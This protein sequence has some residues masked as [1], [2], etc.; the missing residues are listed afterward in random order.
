LFVR[1]KSLIVQ[2]R[3]LVANLP[4]ARL[5]FFGRLA[6]TSF[7]ANLFTQSFPIS[8]QRLQRGL[9]FAP[10][11]VHPQ[12][13]ID[14]SN[15]FIRAAGREATLHKIWLFADKTYV[16]HILGISGRATARKSKS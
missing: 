4:D 6:A 7:A 1:R 5:K 16:E 11:R 9:G 15:V 12:N 8:V 3:N 14:S 10:I 13:I 2:Q